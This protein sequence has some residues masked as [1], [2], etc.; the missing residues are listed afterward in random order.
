LNLILL[1]KLQVTLIINRLTYATAFKTMPCAT[2]HNLYTAAITYWHILALIP[3]C[4]D[5][6]VYKPICFIVIL[7]ILTFVPSII[8]MYVTS[9]RVCMRAPTTCSSHFSRVTQKSECAW[10]MKQDASLDSDVTAV[11]DSCS[12]TSRHHFLRMSV[13]IFIFAPAVAIYTC[14]HTYVTLLRNLIIT[15]TCY[16]LQR[17]H[18]YT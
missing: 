13:N 16:H 9:E 2:P 11:A 3:E 18:K 5:L 17:K 4:I 7:T 8:S 6:S 15:I 12:I 14:H 1:L 10:W